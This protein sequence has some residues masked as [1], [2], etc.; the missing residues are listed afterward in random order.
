M[1]NFQFYK[2]F[3]IPITLN[4][5]NYGKLIYNTN[6]IFIISI[7]PRTLSVIIQDKEFN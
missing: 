6:N 2:H 3:K 5:L 4:P 1:T 7:T